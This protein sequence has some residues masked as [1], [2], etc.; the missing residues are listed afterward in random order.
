MADPSADLSQGKV[1][2]VMPHSLPRP[3]TANWVSLLTLTIV[4]GTAFLAIDTAV[5]TLPPLTLVAIRVLVAALVLCLAVYAVGLR[6]PAPGVLWLRFLLLA[7]VGNA[8]PFTAISWGQQRIDSGLAGVLMAVMPLTTLVLAH[9]FVAGERMTRQRAAGFSLG[10]VG[11]VG[12]TGPSVLAGLGGAPSEVIRQLA[13]L[14]GA[15]CYAVNTILAQ[16]MPAADPVVSAACTM[17]MASALML[18]VCCWID[19]P[20]ELAPSA[21]SMQAAV[22]LGL[23]A[24]GAATVL[25]FRIVTTAGPTFLSLMNYIIPVIAMLTGIA[26]AGE[27]FAWR[28]VAALA[29]ILTGLVVASRAAPRSS[30]TAPGSAL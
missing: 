7:F 23:A 6:L 8:L 30:D 16:R 25:Y 14:S 27:R 21:S 26:F 28:I 10:L 5:E 18:P 17:V 12:L 11:I 29:L 24:T 22:W 3:S 4:W 9:F 2:R 13:I 15:L 20:W 1:V 19:R